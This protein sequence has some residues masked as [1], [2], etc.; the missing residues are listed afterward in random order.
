MG[1]TELYKD[2]CLLLTRLGAVKHRLQP[3]SWRLPCSDSCSLLSVSWR[4]TWDLQ[5]TLILPGIYSGSVPGWLDPHPCF[6]GDLVARWSCAVKPIL[7]AGRQPTLTASFLWE[8][9]IRLNDSSLLDWVFTPLSISTTWK[10]KKRKTRRISCV[11]Q[12]EHTA[13]KSIR[14]QHVHDLLQNY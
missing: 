8:R 12:V 2:N 4:D 1:F 11:S 3:V 7:P 14:A 13:M 5:T 10:Q 6:P 9:I